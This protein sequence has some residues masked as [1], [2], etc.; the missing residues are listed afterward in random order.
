MEQSSRN[1]NTPLLQA[2]STLSDISFGSN[3][4]IVASPA[5]PASHRPGYRRVPSAIEENVV[6]S[7]SSISSP[8]S[9]E[10]LGLGITNFESHE[11][12]AATQGP[13]SDKNS[14]SAFESADPLVSPA[15]IKLGA[16][17]PYGGKSQHPRDEE[18]CVDNS[19]TAQLFQPLT[20]ETDHHKAQSE[21]ENKSFP[22]RSQGPLE[23]GRGS[24]VAV[25]IL[26][27]SIYST[28]FSLLWLIL[29]IARPRYGHAIS[30]VGKVGPIAAS[31]LYAAFA[32]SIEL[33]FVTV[34]VAL[35]GQILSKRALGD[36]KSVTIA[37]MSMR[38][39]VLQPGTMITHWQSMRYAVITRLGSFAILGAIMAMIYTTASDAL[40]APKL[41]LGKAEDRLIYGKVS[42]SFGNQ[43]SVANLCPTPI[44]QDDD[45]ENGNTCIQIQH[46]G[47]A[48]H[49]YIQYLGAWREHIAVGNG[50]AD[51]MKRPDP[52][53][54]GI[55]ML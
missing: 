43:E 45:P 20:A 49:N 27:L 18:R 22:C 4:T 8:P 38:S 29:A 9:K 25:T 1:S 14:R 3:S 41:Q 19:S 44:K 24:W 15:S 13:L 6:H 54:V 32:K 47:E 10:A 36:Q 28:V 12:E 7:A 51:L 46:S 48:Y 17:F 2:S 5:S 35:L 21:F 52:V 53:G 50:S 40:V 11:D 42:A 33:S 34:F 31:I 37:E 16:G 23:T 26:V 55:N 39:W 30:P